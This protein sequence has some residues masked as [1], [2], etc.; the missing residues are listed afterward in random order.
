MKHHP[1]QVHAAG[2]LALLAAALIVPA[3]AVE[4]T[5]Q[6]YRW[7]P[8]KLRGTNA[9]SIQMAEFQFMLGGSPVSWTGASVTNPGGS[10][11]AGEV[12]AY[13]IDGNTGSKWLDFNKGGLQFTFPEPTTVDGYR[14]AT[15]N[16][17]PERDPVSWKL[18]GSND[19]A[20]WTYIDVIK[21]NPTP[22]TRFTY[23]AFTLPVAVVPEVLSF[24]SNI[25]VVRDGNPLYLT[26]SLDL[27][28]SA[29]IAP[30]VG[31]VD[32]FG[33]TEEVV[34]PV[35]ADT[36]YTL[37]AASQG[38]TTPATTMV[39]SVIGGSVN[40]QYLRFT[41]TKLRS[42]TTI[43]LAEFL[44]FNA[45]EPVVPVAVANPGG[46]NLPDANEGALKLID[47]DP[48]TKW[49][50]TAL[51]PLVFDF[52]TTATFDSYRFTTGNDAPER[53]PLRWT[54]E[55]SDNGV[56]WE[57][58]E[59]MTAFDFI[60]P[61]AR[62]AGSQDVPFPG[63]SLI[64]IL[65]ASTNFASILIG[66]A[67][68][69]TWTS[70]GAATVT[71]TPTPG[72]L[73]FAGTVTESPTVSTT[74]VVT[75][76]AAGGRTFVVELPVTVANPTVNTIAYE[77]FDI[78]GSEINL[79]NAAAIVNDFAN[80]PQG[81][82][83]K[84]LR[85]TPDIGSLSGAAWFRYQQ[86]ASHGFNASFDFHFPTVSNDGADG[87]AMVIHN[88]PRRHEAMPDGGHEFGLT[89]NAL[90]IC[91]DSYN[92]AEGSAA[93]LLVRANATTLATVNLATVAGITLFTSVQGQ[94]LTD[95]TRAGKS[96]RVDI[97]YVPGN[98]NVSFEGIPVV[99][100]LNVNLGDIGAL[101]ADGKAYVGFTARTGG[102]Y[103]AHDVTRWLFTPGS[104]PA[105]FAAWAAANAPGQTMDMDHDQD[106]VPNGIEYFMG[107]SGSSFTATP[108]PEAD[109]ILSWPKGAEYAGTYGTGYKVQTSTDLEQWT[110]VLAADPNLQDGNPV[111]YQLTRDGPRKFVRLM[112]TE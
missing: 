102:S 108:Q 86:Q 63:A 46:W 29:E 21:D 112:V 59:N 56:D 73:D 64:P 23:Q 4:Q 1:N 13:V 75:A 32:P 107:L 9:N 110:D 60:M 31:A 36:V 20:T 70:V 85:V 72:E 111:R 8:T 76:T 79:L 109:D 22:V 92:N 67:V 30:G 96:F 5:F 25:S 48:G 106:G 105:G 45:G 81:G 58:V 66:E 91:L 12:P 84:R 88:H 104:A 17:S 42:G 95:V 61:T 99:N 41:P 28:D 97:S 82:D 3:A 94:T 15:A 101:D 71:C 62:Q 33:G 98:L 44:F 47:G 51:R 54:M 16:D 10:N 52:G 34:P 49:L 103:E 90:N 53:D 7:M 24:T 78:A 93:R 57:L 77:N 18:S 35:N 6:F 80:L 2:L 40:A 83:V 89:T 43:Q 55:A 68:N 87:M 100:N 69:I 37:T 14:I 74:Y 19:G 11:P 26:W 65:S 27:A 38:G 50:D 39:R